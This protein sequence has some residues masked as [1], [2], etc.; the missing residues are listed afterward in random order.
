VGSLLG[1]RLGNLLGRR[2]G[3]V[4]GTSL[5]NPRVGREDRLGSKL[6]LGTLL[7]FTLGLELGP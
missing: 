4:L 1:N 5:V 3:S 2:L 7:G 6:E